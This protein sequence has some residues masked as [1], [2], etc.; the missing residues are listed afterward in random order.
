M[1]ARI[2]S[3]FRGGHRGRATVG[4]AAGMALA[5]VVGV[6]ALI[7]F[8][9]GTSGPASATDVTPTLVLGNADCA[10]QGGVDLIKIEPVMDGMFSL[11]G[12]GMIEIA[13]QNSHFDWTST[14]SIGYI[15]VKGGR[16]A[17]LYDYRPL[18]PVLTF[19][20]TGL[21]APTNPN[22]GKFFGLSHISF[23]DPGVIVTPT[24]TPETVPT[25]CRIDCPAP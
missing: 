22:N 25:K 9:A 11:P 15:L 3:L 14:V 8:S 10:S 20:D 6:A 19:A 24:P 2:Q 18:L 16:E 12:G 21:H 5:L 17:N 4:L 13:V 7:A 1:T 23:C